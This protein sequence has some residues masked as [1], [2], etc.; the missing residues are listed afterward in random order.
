MLCYLG[1]GAR[2]YG[3]NPIPIYRRYYWEFQAVLKGSIGMRIPDCEPQFRSR[4]LWLSAPEHE[5]GWTGKPDEEAEVAVFHFLSIPELVKQRFTKVQCQEF[6]LSAAQ[7][8][9]IR[10]LAQKVDITWRSPR[11]DM[12]LRHEHLLL[13]LSLL[14]CAENPAEISA[15]DRLQR[16]RVDRALSWFNQ[17]MQFNPSQEE[18][19]SAA[20]VS[21]AHLRRLFHAVMQTSPKQ[22]FDQLRLQRAIHLM[23]DHW[24]KLEVVGE[25]CGYQSASAFSRAFKNK[26]GCSPDQW[27]GGRL[28]RDQ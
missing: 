17:H 22:A 19:A 20:G 13:E 16:E 18:V 21:P 2:R 10:E 12:T 23:T 28:K 8:Q 9:R 14:V 6:P 27:R 15:Q 24:Q 1:I 7:C 26:F 4:L 5:H 11:P 25:A 3:E